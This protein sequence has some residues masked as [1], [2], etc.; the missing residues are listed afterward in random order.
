MTRR[1][2]GFLVFRRNGEAEENVLQESGWVEGMQERDSTN[3][4]ASR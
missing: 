3:R 2:S 1:Q 4:K